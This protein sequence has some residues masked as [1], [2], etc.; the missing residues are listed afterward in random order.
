MS[1]KQTLNN[2]G[3]LGA[4]HPTGGGGGVYFRASIDTHYTRENVRNENTDCG[5]LGL[6]CC[7]IQ[8]PLQI[9]N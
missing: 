1:V 3:M 6:C 7:K 2:Q 8:M 9:I 4:S 5:K